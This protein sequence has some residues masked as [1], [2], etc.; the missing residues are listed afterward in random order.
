MIRSTARFNRLAVAF[1]VLIAYSTPTLRGRLAV[2]L[3]AVPLAIASNLARVLV[4]VLLSLW[5]G[6]GILDVLQ[7]FHG[8]APRGSGLFSRH[9]RWARMRM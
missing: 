6:F 8:P 7:L 2:L 3:A 1:A 5:Q 4:L 9:E